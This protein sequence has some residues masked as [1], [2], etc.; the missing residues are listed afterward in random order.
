MIKT[1]KSFIPFF[2]LLFMLLCYQTA[3]SCTTVIISGKA[4]KDGRPLLWK[5]CDTPNLDQKVYFGSDRGYPFIGLMR[6][7]TANESRGS[8]WT[9]TNSEGFTIMN[10]LSY[11]IAEEYS[12]NNNGF[13]MRRALEVCK[14]IAS[15]KHFLD[16]LSRPMKVS[17]NFGVIDAN[18]GAAY[19]ETWD[20]GY[21]MSDVNDPAVAPLGYLVYTNFSYNGIYDKGQ[22]YIRYQTAVEIMAKGAPAKAFTPQW[23]FSNLSRSFYHSL[24]GVDLAL[25]QS[26]NLTP[27]GWFADSDFIPRKSTATSCVVH[28]VKPGENPEFTTMWVILGYPPCSV[29]IPTWVKLKENQ[30]ALLTRTATSENVPISDWALTLK[31]QVFPITRG[32]GEKY[33][34][35]GRLYSH[36]DHSGFMQQLAPLE[37]E[38][39]KREAVLMESWR[40]QSINVKEAQEFHASIYVLVEKKM[41]ELMIR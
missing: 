11:N 14:D 22:G 36:T 41:Q 12:A 7:N 18:G 19:F 15:F 13:L 16:T 28:G 2:T 6:S 30:P 34:N 27:N 9:G 4:T 8:I 5:N 38:C 39:F 10:T 25:P 3:W 1:I 29:A 35:F 32:S 20:E 37:D 17:A 24:L 23:I 26:V 40:K 31:E 33:F 21:Y